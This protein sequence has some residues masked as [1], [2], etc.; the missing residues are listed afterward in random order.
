MVTTPSGEIGNTA[1][2]SGPKEGCLK[3]M[4]GTFMT[5]GKYAWQLQYQAAMLET[6]RGRLPQRIREAQ[7]VIDARL[8]ELRGRQDLAP[9]EQDAI[10][11]ALTGLNVL[12]KE[13]QVH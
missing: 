1:I 4:D 2:L 7:A 3:T 11:D 8:K 6:N 13:I 10:H 12:R 5:L 9:D